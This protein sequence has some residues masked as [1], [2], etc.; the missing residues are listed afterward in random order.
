MIKALQRRGREARTWLQEAAFPLWSEV[1]TQREAFLPALALNHRP[2]DEELPLDLMVQA[3]QAEMFARALA[4]GWRV[5]RCQ[6]LCS[7]ALEHLTGPGRRPDGLLAPDPEAPE[8]DP[9]GRFA[10]SVAG[11]SALLA[12]AEADAAL[13]PDAMAAAEA[14]LKA[15]DGALH[16]P[17]GSGYLSG[18]PGT[19]REAGPHC[20]LLRAMIARHRLDRGSDAMGRAGELV[21]LFLRHLAGGEPGLVAA[22]HQADWTA[23]PET[24]Y[25]LAEQFAWAT[26][27]VAYSAAAGTALPDEALRL[28]RF[29]ADLSDAEGGLPR[30]VTAAG[31]PHDE[32]SD[33]ETHAAALTAHLTVLQVTGDETCALRAAANF[34]TLMD[35]HLTPEGGWI[36][37]FDENGLPTSAE[38]DARLGAPLVAALAGLIA[39][40]EA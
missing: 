35:T 30:S 18:A 37:R 25:P 28:Y 16:G 11:L 10:R 2:A 7:V 21:A 14:L 12:M 17:R 23:G 32:A 40:V 38:M 39:L 1:G 22:R 4:L 29:A 36:G 8:A 33:L 3:R 26:A 13:R 20:E 27:L 15:L 31:E 34:D 24:D 19:P 5:E 6:A 9:D